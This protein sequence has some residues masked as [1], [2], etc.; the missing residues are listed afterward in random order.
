VTATL[1]VCNSLKLRGLTCESGLGRSRLEHKWT[2]C[3]QQF[4]PHTRHTVEASETAKWTVFGSPRDD[5]LSQRRTD[6]RQSCDL[7]HVGAIEIDSFTREKRAS[8]LGG[9]TS[10]L[11][12][13]TWLRNGCRLESN[14]TGW[15]AW[16]RGE[17]KPNRSTGQRQTGEEESSAAIVHPSTYEGQLNNSDRKNAGHALL[18]AQTHSGEQATVSRTTLPAT[19]SLQTAVRL[20]V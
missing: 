10:R 12:E 13:T 15:I 11:L 3:V 9:T 17:D 4:W 20:C 5:P 14:V 19:C 8:K 2:D 16:R 6:A 18:D 1:A 7:A